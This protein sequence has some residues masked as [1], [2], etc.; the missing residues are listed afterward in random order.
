[1]KVWFAT[2]GIKVKDIRM[3]KST[4]GHVA[5]I[6]CSGVHAKE[7]GIGDPMLLKLNLLAL[8]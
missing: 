1:M 2:I 4:F 7:Q 3:E 8:C 6:I 5:E